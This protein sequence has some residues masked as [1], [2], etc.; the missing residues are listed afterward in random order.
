M[1]GDLRTPVREPELQHEELVEDQPAAGGIAGFRGLGEVEVA[2]GGPAIDQA[3][4]RKQGDR[5][6]IRDE[7]AEGVDG[8][9]HGLAEGLEVEALGEGIDRDD[10]ADVDRLA[11]GFAGAPQD[12]DVRAIEGDPAGE[13]VELGFARDEDLGAY[14]IALLE[15]LDLGP[16]GLALEPAGADAPSAVRDMDGHDAHVRPAGRMESLDAL[17]AA[18][19]GH[20]LA[21]FEVA[22]ARARLVV[23]V[24]AGEVVKQIPDGE[25]ADLAE[26]LTELGADALHVL[27]GLVERAGRGGD[28]RRRA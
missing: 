27:N 12:L 17:D 9:V 14:R 6:G 13:L 25:D 21:L 28:R 20:A 11:L 8:G 5:D 2:D 23:Q 26:K 10:T 1:P 16:S 19:E 24:G 3:V 22:N 18:P 7:V 15:E 4:A